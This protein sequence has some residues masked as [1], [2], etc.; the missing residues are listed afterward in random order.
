M[1]AGQSVLWGSG[2]QSRLYYEDIPPDVNEAELV[3]PCIAELPLGKAP[4]DWRIPFR[5]KPAPP[6]LKVLPVIEVETPTVE[7]TPSESAVDKYGIAFGLE[8]VVTLDDGYVLLGSLHWTCAYFISFSGPINLSVTDANGEEL[9][10]EMDSSYSNFGRHAEYNTIPWAVRIQVNL[11]LRKPTYFSFNTGP[12]PTVGQSWA[13]DRE[14]SV[15]GLPIRVVSA[16]MIT[17]KGLKGFEFNIQAPL[18][19][20]FLQVGFEYSPGMRMPP[21]VDYLN[22]W[23]ERE[24]NETGEFISRITTEAEINGGTINLSINAVELAGPWSVDWNPPAAMGE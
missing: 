20:Y 11:T 2:Y 19:F 8:K 1:N 24:E 16:K 10:A 13:L 5:L 6:D 3:I 18:E 9:P 14:F 22:A 21:T 12:D 7:T 4:E 15:A 23:G 17:L